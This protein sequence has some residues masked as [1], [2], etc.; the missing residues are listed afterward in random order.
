MATVQDVSTFNTLAIF[1]HKLDI[2]LARH[3]EAEADVPRLETLDASLAANIVVARLKNLEA[4]IADLEELGNAAAE[5]TNERHSWCKQMR[6]KLQEALVRLYSMLRE[7]SSAVR[8]AL[9][10]N[11]KD[12]A[13]K[14]ANRA[15][16][17][18]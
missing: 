18:I 9:S 13:K 3:A 6:F 8:L 17:Q 2:E 1:L 10:T 4:E 14:L 12:E 5:E 11:M 16:T 7:F 15:P